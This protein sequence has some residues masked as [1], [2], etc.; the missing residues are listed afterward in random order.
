MLE[1]QHHI[2]RIADH[3]DI[4]RGEVRSKTLTE[5]ALLEMSGNAATQASG[6]RL[7]RF[8]TMGLLNLITSGLL[9][10]REQRGGVELV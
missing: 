7:S 9:V 8:R 5:P 10:T 4:A 1:P 6:L 3:D 2:V